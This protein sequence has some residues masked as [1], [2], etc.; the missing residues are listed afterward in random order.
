M[1]VFYRASSIPNIKSF[2]VRILAETGL[3]G[4]AAFLTWYYVLWRSSRFLQAASQPLLQTIALS[5]QF[6]LLAFLFEGFSTDTFALPYLW[7]SLGMVSAASAL[8]RASLKN[9]P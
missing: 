8:W 2:W 5:G 7:V 4:F 9:N 6:V 3:V 1:D